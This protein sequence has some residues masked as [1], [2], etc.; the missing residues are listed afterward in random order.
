M[1]CVPRASRDRRPSRQS[2]FLMEFGR[3][4]AVTLPAAWAMSPVRQ[5]P[6]G[7]GTGG[8]EVKW[9]GVLPDA[10]STVWYQYL[11]MLGLTN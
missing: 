9:K 3:R 4:H 1:L 11:Y 6:S 8:G 10:G 2:A 7:E 5:T